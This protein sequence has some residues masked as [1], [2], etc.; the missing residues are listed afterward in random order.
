MKKILV[1]VFVLIASYGYAQDLKFGVKAGLNLANTAGSD[2]EDNK[3]NTRFYFGG[4]LNTPISDIVSFQPELLISMQGVKAD[5]DMSDISAEI[6][7]TYLNIPLLFKMRLGS[8]NTA[9]FYAGPQLGFVL[10]AEQEVEMGST[11]NTEDIKEIMNTVDFSLNLGFSF[12][13][14]EDLALDLRYNRGFTKLLEDGG[15]AYNSVIQL[16][17]SYSF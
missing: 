17:A 16:G 5:V 9:H 7:T 2:V 12:N 8:S 3:V 6:N 10:K 13:V 11:T 15:K 14:S 4:F 1:I